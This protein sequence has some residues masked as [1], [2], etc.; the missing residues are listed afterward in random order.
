LR[1]GEGHGDE[2]RKRPMHI[3]KDGGTKSERPRIGIRDGYMNTDRG[4]G[5]TGWRYGGRQRE[6]GDNQ[7]RNRKTR[8]YG[9]WPSVISGLIGQFP[10]V[11]VLSVAFK[12]LQSPLSF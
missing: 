9:R 2:R 7:M 1:H 10:D 6:T 4:D 5:K 3:P 8:V 12:S 11:T